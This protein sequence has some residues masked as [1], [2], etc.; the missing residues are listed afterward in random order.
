M[1]ATELL[2]I[3]LVAVVL[4]VIALQV[5][6]LLRGRD[7]EKARSD[8]ESRL[9]EASSQLAYAQAQA[10]RAVTMEREFKAAQEDLSARRAELA[11]MSSQHDAAVRNLAVANEQIALLTTAGKT[12]AEERSVLL[13]SQARLEQEVKSARQREIDTGKLLTDAKEEMAKEFKLMASTLLEEKGARLN[14]QQKVTLSNL[15]GPFSKTLDDFKGK[16]EATRE[17][18][19]TAREGLIAQIRHLT[20][21]NQDIGAKAQSLTNALRGESKT[22]G[23]WGETVLQRVLELAGLR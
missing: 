3:A 23:I 12:F 1:S 14:E 2:L 4:V 13:E 16:V 7:A 9:R 8:A 19:L 10:E 6:V 17:A 20:E 15:L 21:L 18:D 22:R 11:S 5:T